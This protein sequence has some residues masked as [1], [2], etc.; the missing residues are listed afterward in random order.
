[1]ILPCN[2]NIIYI[3]ATSTGYENDILKV[4]SS[5]QVQESIFCKKI[6]KFGGKSF[7]KLNSVEFMELVFS[8]SEGWDSLSYLLYKSVYRTCSDLIRGFTC[9]LEA[10]PILHYHGCFCSNLLK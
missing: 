8:K 10:L 2:L 3:F 6:Y 5:L 4:I 7:K 1:M 9:D